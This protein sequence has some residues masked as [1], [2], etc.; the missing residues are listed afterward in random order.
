MKKYTLVKKVY[1]LWSDMA[2][3]LLKLPIQTE[4]NIKQ[5]FAGKRVMEIRDI[6]KQQHL[7]SMKGFTLNRIAIF[8][9][10][11]R[12]CLF[13]VKMCKNQLWQVGFY[14]F[15]G[16]ARNFYAFTEALSGLF[17]CAEGCCKTLIILKT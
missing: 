2:N 13:F 16:L 12:I 5:C 7:K 8:C 11:L 9:I 10:D 3:K 6:K 1:L 15:F 4:S 17:S 14:A